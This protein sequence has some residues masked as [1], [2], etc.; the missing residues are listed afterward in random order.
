MPHFLKDNCREIPNV[1]KTI[2][3]RKNLG[4]EKVF[5]GNEVKA[6]SGSEGLFRLDNFEGYPI[7]RVS[8]SYEV[9]DDYPLEIIESYLKSALEIYMP[10]EEQHIFSAGN[11]LG[12]EKRP[13]G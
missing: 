5:P 11:L 7:G 1:I 2:S 6:G 4:V 10:P 12:Y 13:W 9:L 8:F 3:D